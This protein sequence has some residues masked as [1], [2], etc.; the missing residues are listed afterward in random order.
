[1]AEELEMEGI[2]GGNLCMLT[3]F[4]VEL[5]GGGGGGGRAASYVGYGRGICVKVED[6]V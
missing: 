3:M 5:G 1:M 6:E 2:G 4:G